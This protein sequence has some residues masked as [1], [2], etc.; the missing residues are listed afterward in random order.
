MSE[1]L[2]SILNVWLK[3]VLRDANMSAESPGVPKE[4]KGYSRERANCVLSKYTLA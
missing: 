1:A 2:K 4:V 3:E